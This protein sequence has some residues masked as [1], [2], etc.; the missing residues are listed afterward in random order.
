MTFITNMLTL[1]LLGGCYIHWERGAEVFEELLIDHETACNVGNWQWLACVA[2]YS[3]YYR[4]YSPIAFPQK[5]DKEGAFVRRYVPELKDMPTK[6]IYEPWKAPIQD[7][8]KAGVMI[9]GDGEQEKEGDLNLYPKPIF[10]FAKQREICINGLKSAYSIGLYGDSPQVLDGTW[11]KMF[12]DDAEGPTQGDKGG[13]AGSLGDAD[14]HGTEEL[15]P[16]T[17]ATPSKKR[18]GQSTLEKAF[19]KAKT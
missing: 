19:K 6:Y 13:P 14:A 2:F 12:D 3:Q 15:K 4:C 16:D 7:Q 5:W 9:K 10:D 1:S 17:K 11:K 18:G 8:K